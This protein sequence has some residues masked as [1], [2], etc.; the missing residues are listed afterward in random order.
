MNLPADD[1]EVSFKNGSSVQV[2]M[3]MGKGKNKGAMIT[4]NWRVVVQ[5]TNMKDNDIFVFWFRSN[6]RLKLL[7]R[8]LKK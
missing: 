5:D 2:R 1:V 4:T 7:V 8:K 6:G 3:I